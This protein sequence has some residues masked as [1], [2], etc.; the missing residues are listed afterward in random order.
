MT[1][2]QT[3]ALPIYWDERQFAIPYTD[4]RKTWKIFF[5]TDKS[6]Q[7]QTVQRI[8]TVPQRTVCVLINENTKA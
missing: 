2:V 4:K 6:I 7:K 5:I 3:C 8:I 1:G